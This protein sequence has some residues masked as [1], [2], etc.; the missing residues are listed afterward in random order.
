MISPYKISD[1]EGAYNATGLQVQRDALKAVGLALPLLL[2]PFIARQGQAFEIVTFVLVLTTF[3]A[4]RTPTQLIVILFAYY[5]VDGYLRLLFEYD[6]VIYQLPLLLTLLVYVRWFFSPQWR[7]SRSI[8]NTSPIALPLMSLVGLYVLQTLNG[9]PWN[10]LISVGGFVYHL[11]AMPL[12][13][14]AATGFRNE[15][16]VRPMLWFIVGLTVFECV[17]AIV[18]NYLGPSH[19]L[20]L[21]QHYQARLQMEAWWTPGGN[22]LIYRPTGLT[23]GGGG[24][25]VYGFIGILVAMG[26]LEGWRPTIAGKLGMVL[27]VFAMLLALLL[28]SIRAFWLALLIGLGVFAV[29]RRNVRYLVLVLAIGA[30]ASALAINATRGALSSRLLPLLTPWDFFT[31]ERGSD[32]SHLPAIIAH[33]PLGIGLGRATGSASGQ[34]SQM[35]PEGLYGYAHNYWVSI[36]WEAS[37]LAPILLAWLLLR[38]GR[39]GLDT[40]RM[41]PSR[42]GR[43]IIAAIL[44]IDA[45]IVAM[46][47]AGPSL[48]GVSSSF[49]QFFWLLSGLLLA[50]RTSWKGS[51]AAT[52][53]PS[54]LGHPNSETPVVLQ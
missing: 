25:G 3:L 17:Y 49:A 2:W 1:S 13:F 16:G 33:Y 8:L 20:A 39:L 14:I 54:T 27:S 51:Q 40:L 6:W 35:F 48:A 10:P 19:A 41:A 22:E 36:T 50:L 47:F 24:P 31:E 23:I 52:V 18:Q 45:G 5:G 21:S 26:L 9:V 29:Y 42:S 44:G 11:G 53:Q 30:G 37:I 32:L 38:L 34:A 15:Q 4:A 7:R 12:F 43:G 46:T 28:S